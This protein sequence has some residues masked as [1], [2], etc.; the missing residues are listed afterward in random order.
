MVTVFNAGRYR[1]D[2]YHS[3]LSYCLT[4]KRSQLEVFAQGDEA[5]AFQQELEGTQ[6]MFAT[7]DEV[8][9]WLW[10]QCNWGA[11]SLPVD[12]YQFA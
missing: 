1:L 11:A 7:W 9:A 5:R 10:D 8:A 3:G 2:S 12:N 6:D 4:D